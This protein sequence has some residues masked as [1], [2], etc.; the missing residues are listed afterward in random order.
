MELPP[1][2]YEYRV[3]DMNEQQQHS[4]Q[5]DLSE[6]VRKAF[7]AVRRRDLQEVSELHSADKALIPL[8]APYLRDQDE[9]VRR[10]AVSLLSVIAGPDALPELVNAL[11]D[12][13]PEICERAA[14]A[15]YANYD[16]SSFTDNK[17]LGSA[18]AKIISSER[19][20][21]AAFLLSAYLPTEEVQAALQVAIKR[22]PVVEVKLFAF[23][24]PVSALLPIQVAM[25]HHGSGEAQAALVAATEKA[26]VAEAEFLLAAIREADSSYILRALAKFLDDTRQATTILHSAPNI[27]LR[28]CDLATNA[29]VKRLDLKVSFK[30]SELKQYDP[31]QID[32]V[33]RLVVQA[34]PDRPVPDRPVAERVKSK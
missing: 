27:R 17:S 30:Q 33:R 11:K 5:H 6:R 24:T 14:M 22:R 29:F 21:A 12:T 1:T 18:L 28:I 3:I 26:S 4:T 32:E 2:Y 31:G 34:V 8:L 19:V 15:L 10:E 13:S 16:P 25:A 7:D 9:D 23:S 20:S